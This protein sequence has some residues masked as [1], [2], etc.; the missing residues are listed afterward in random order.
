MASIL[1]VHTEKEVSKL[2]DKDR[3]LLKE[4]SIQLL[5]NSPEIREVLSGDPKLVQKILKKHKGLHNT[6]RKGSR[7]FLKRLKGG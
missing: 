7:P 3:E 6:V 4:H 1:G 5:L 2:T